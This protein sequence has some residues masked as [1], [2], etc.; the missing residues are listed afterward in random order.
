M[1]WIM[2]NGTTL[3]SASDVFKVDFVCETTLLSLLSGLELSSVETDYWRRQ[4]GS[5]GAQ[6]PLQ[7]AGQKYF[8]G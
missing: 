8:F 3:W 6:P 4:G 1:L 2:S 5:Q 7:M